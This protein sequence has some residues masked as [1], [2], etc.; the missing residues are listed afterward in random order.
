MNISL[1]SIAILYTLTLLNDVFGLGILFFAYNFAVVI[2]I[3]IYYADY[4]QPNC[5]GCDTAIKTKILGF[6]LF[7]TTITDITSL[8][9]FRESIIATNKEALNYFVF[10]VC[11][12]FTVIKPAACIALK[13]DRYTDVI[14][15]LMDKIITFPV[16]S[17]LV[18]I[19]GIL[20]SL[21]LLSVSINFG[22][23]FYLSN[24]LF[25]AFQCF[26][27]IITQRPSDK[28]KRTPLLIFIVSVVIAVDLM[29]ILLHKKILSLYVYTIYYINTAYMNILCQIQV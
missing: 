23:L 21:S 17:V 6:L 10:G 3:L 26:L 5:F 15:R 7:V 27:I 19:D 12:S 18:F 8:I 24:P 25:I 1:C 20:F 11:I 29:S 9:Y 22:L 14:R 2:S 28:P 4:L 16:L 13:L